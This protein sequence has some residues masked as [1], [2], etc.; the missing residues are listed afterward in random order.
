MFNIDAGIPGAEIHM[1]VLFA[2]GAMVGILGGF[3]GVGGGWIITPTLH[4][5]GMPM[6]YAVGTGLAYLTGMSLISAIKHKSANAI[7]PG[8]AITLGTAMV[9]GIQAGK[10]TLM[11]LEARGMADEILRILYILLLFALGFFMLRDCL[12]RGNSPRDKTPAKDQ[13]DRAYAQ[14]F[15]LWPMLHFKT[16]DIK[17]SFWAVAVI[18][19]CIGFFS[20]LLGAGGG[21]LLVPALYYLIGTPTIVAVGT[22]LLCILIASPF[23]TTIYAIEG[24]VNFPA[25]LT[26]LLGAGLGAPLGVRAAHAVKGTQMRFF[27]SLMIMCGGIS[28]LLKELDT[29]LESA[30][31]TQ[32]SRIVIFA[33]GGGIVAT[34]MFLWFKTVILS[35]KELRKN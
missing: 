31:L 2:L 4:I 21:F 28:V 3:F 30:L 5:L 10:S 18:G 14:N 34:I 8:L 35:K 17:V 6:P 27:Y 22:S 20:G 15:A 19:V 7:E 33:A 16:S 23:G 26:M 29:R 12:V 13:L 1:A 25:T 32:A 24:H 9:I 11:G